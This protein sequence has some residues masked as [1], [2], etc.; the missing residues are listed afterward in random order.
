[1]KADR[2]VAPVVEQA[3]QFLLWL[4]PAVEKFPRSQ[5]FLLGDRIQANALSLLESLTEAAYVRQRRPVL[6]RANLDIERL[7]LLIRLSKDLRHLDMRRYEYAARH[8]DEIGRQV[9]GW[10]RASGDDAPAP[11]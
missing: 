4:I 7:R 9:G 6:R 2:T 8:L 11:A 5:K 3:Y 1:M 10:M